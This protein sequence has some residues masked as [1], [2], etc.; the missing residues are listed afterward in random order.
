MNFSVEKRFLSLFLAFV[1]VM[2]LLPWWTVDVDAAAHTSDPTTYE[3]EV[4][5]NSASSEGTIKQFGYSYVT[6]GTSATLTVWVDWNYYK[7]S[8]GCDAY[9]ANKTK[10]KL[11]N[12]TELGQRL[13]FTQSS[14]E[15]VG[16]VTIGG[17]TFA[18]TYVKEL[19]A[20]E[21]IEIIVNPSNANTNVVAEL[22]LSI[23]IETSKV[24]TT[25]FAS[26]ENGSY[27]VTDGTVT[28][29]VAAGAASETFLNETAVQYTMS[30]TPDAGYKFLGWYNETIGAYISTDKTFT[31]Q[32]DAAYTIKPVVVSSSAPIFKVGS[33]HFT[34]LSAANT[35]AADGSNKTIV[36][37]SDGTLPAGE[38]KISTG[39][40]LL[41]PFDDAY[42]SYG[43]SPKTEQPPS[44]SSSSPTP[45]PFK[46]LT[47]QDGTTIT[48]DGAIEVA[49]KHFSAHG[50]DNVGGRPVEYY[51]YIVMEGSSKIIL[52]DDAKLY[53]WGY[54]SGSSEA[55]VIAES[56]ATI[57]EKMQVTDYRG[58]RATTSIAGNRF[59]PFSQYYVQNVEVKETIKYGANL[60]A[61]ATVW[62]SD[63]QAMPLNFIGTNCMFTLE[64]GSHVTKYYDV[65]TDRLILD[66]VGDFSFNPIE[67]KFKM[68]ITY[69]YNTKDFILPMQQNMTINLLSGS[70]TVNQD[71]LLQPGCVVNVGED[72]TLTVAS[73]K[74]IYLMDDAEWSTYC[75]GYALKQLTYVPTRK[76]APVT[77]SVNSNA[78][79][80]VD[81]TVVVNGQIYASASHASVVS[82]NKTGKFIFNTDAKASDGIIQYTALDSGKITLTMT[83]L[84]LIGLTENTDTTGTKAGTM[85]IYCATHD[86]WNNGCCVTEPCGHT[87]GETVV[88]NN[89]DPDCVKEGSYDNVVYCTVCGEVLSR[90]TITLDALGHKYDNACDAD[91]NVCSAPRTPSDH[92]PG[93]EATCTTA[94]ICTVCKDE[95]KPALGHK[96]GDDDGDCTTAIKCTVCQ[97]VTTEAKAHVF[98]EAS[99]DWVWDAD[100]NTYVCTASRTCQNCEKGKETLTEDAP[101]PTVTPGTCT[102]A[103][104]MTYTVQ[105][106]EEW[107]GEKSHPVSGKIDPDN[108]AYDETKNESNLTRPV[109]VDD[110][111]TDG[112]YT[113]TCKNDPSHT[114]T[115]KVER[116]DYSAFAKAEQDL[117]GLLD[118][119]LT[120]QAIEA[121]KAALVEAEKIANNLIETEQD[122]LDT[123][124][125]NLTETYDKYY[126]AFKSYTVTFVVN[127]ETVKTETVFSGNDATAPE[128]DPTKEPD[129]TYHYEFF[130]WDNDFKEIKADITVTAQFTATAHTFTHIDKDDIHHTDA[131]ECGYSA[132]VEHSYDKGVIITDPTCSAKGEKTFTCS[133]C[134]GTKTEEVAIDETAHKWKTEYTVDTKASCDKE[135]KKS[136]HCEYC[137]TINAESVVAI[138]QRTHNIVD[139][140]VEKDATCT[141]TGTMNQKCDHGATDEYDACTYTTT[142]EIQKDASKHTGAANVTQGYKDATCTEEG[143]TGDIHW[144][145]CD[146]LEQNG[147]TISALG[148][149]FDN[150]TDTTCNFCDFTR[151]ARIGDK[152]YATLA[153]AI[154]AAEEDDTIVL[155][156]QIVVGNGQNVTIEGNVTIVTTVDDA[157]AANAGGKLTLVGVT[158]K[159]NTAI[160]WANG[161]TIEVDGATLSSTGSQYAVAFAEKNGHINV[162]SGKIEAIDGTS[163]TVS[164]KNATVNISDGEVLNNTTS[165]VSAKDKAVIEI[166]GGN[167]KTTATSDF[168]CS[169]YAGSGATIKV[170]GGT[171]TTATTYAVVAVANGK[172]EVSGGTINGGVIAHENANASANISGGVINGDVSARNGAA[173]KVS[174][175][176]F[177]EDVTEYCVAGF[178]TVDT[179]GNGVFT[180]GEHSYAEEVTA[181]T[182]TEK[183]YTTY[184]CNCGDS[185]VDDYVNANDHTPGEAVRENEV[186]STCYA[187]GS[188]DE[189]V[190]CSV[191]AC[192]HEIS[193]T[194]KTIDK[195]EHT[196]AEAVRENEVD[197]TCYAEGSYDEVVYCSVEAC[198]HEISRTSKTIEKK[199]HTPGE[200]V[201]ENEVDSTCYAE[202][203]YDE[204]VYCSVEACKHEISRTEKTIDKKDHSHSTYSY[205]IEYHWSVCACGEELEDTKTAHSFENGACVCGLKEIAVEVDD[206]ID[207]NAYT[208]SG[209]VV[210]VTH[211]VAC[212]VGYLNEDG[213]YVALTA[214]ENDDGS[215]SFTAPVE[216]AEVLITVKGDA[217]GDGRVTAADIARINAYIKQKTEDLTAAEIFAGDVDGN[218][219]LEAEDIDALKADV[220]R[221]ATLQ[222]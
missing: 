28:K 196:P 10:I 115:E 217:N 117:R 76:G 134:S 194:E 40:T 206:A 48:V 186:D 187:E 129:A 209:R 26:S 88:E 128:K 91:C 141:A 161:G 4:N 12:N 34:D 68:L 14:A 190:Y 3:Y 113:F 97:T 84:H 16:N 44:P 123:E 176:S 167:V 125:A 55:Q 220:L 87:A 218:G 59:F 172:V 212:K 137:D 178:H 75:C 160:L 108:H 65:A 184:T 162:K 131:C 2:A 92:V 140:T 175:G 33:D 221:T 146:A 69:T 70:A 200:A 216:A 205:N 79:V 82:E 27:T 25:T 98:G 30:A 181:P 191:E 119:D 63:A 95:L 201:R 198:K 77:R 122:I 112:Y 45:K 208:V 46:T 29:T 22:V 103:E 1:M 179:A 155:L 170:T 202:G 73:G 147:E 58:G 189:V 132:D 17:E 89:V 41:I 114:K 11:T 9:T 96:D 56:G 81:G 169:A 94:Q 166:S 15:K 159:S 101:A 120:D 38:Y 118:L 182:C 144:S 60:I 21:T 177:I 24:V 215:Y 154:A 157:F 105:F 152:S 50:N 51:G 35:A 42:T 85:Y 222:W 7:N 207:S 138:E 148:H 130:E 13:T 151:E 192:K 133:I 153:E 8:S 171:V 109:L 127:G 173:V 102:T 5:L 99:Y 165:A 199:N 145:C 64:E 74:G 106:D 111:W 142:R 104:V 67:I 62:A 86:K 72:V 213:A 116:A 156:K 71:I 195:K 31:T 36:L 32:F 80:N 90:N 143:Y 219:V 204:V 110:V 164:A 37:I 93:A 210:T 83:P 54:I 183:G 214:A 66:V 6:E 150:D 197:S 57:Y 18:D 163:V 180:Y 185:Y 47:I 174:G 49:A 53:A 203:S 107:A 43:A 39:V 168:Y 193:R 149:R 124:T 19:I 121:I 78:K 211:S 100:S 136:Y 139:T 126:R 23:A 61:H 158:V 52:N 20:G 135:G 188:Y